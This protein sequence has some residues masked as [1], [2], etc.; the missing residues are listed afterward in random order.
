MRVLFQIDIETDFSFADGH[1]TVEKRPIDPPSSE[2]L[3]EKISTHPQ[4]S[5]VFLNDG[6]RGVAIVN[7]G[8]PE[9]EII[10]SQKGNT[11]AITLL[12]AVGWLSRDDCLEKGGRR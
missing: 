10:R 2:E 5:Y 7:R 12:R 1:F 3:V 9:Y 6:R 4:K 8:L 11:I